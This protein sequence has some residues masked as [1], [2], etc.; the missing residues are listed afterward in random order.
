VLYI[1][2]FV[3]ENLVRLVL[4][5]LAKSKVTSGRQDLT[6]WLNDKKTETKNLLTSRLEIVAPYLAIID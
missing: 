1:N 6:L 5:F 2:Q 3:F 4:M